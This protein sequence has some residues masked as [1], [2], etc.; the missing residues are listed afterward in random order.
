MMRW[1]CR[2]IYEANRSTEVSITSNRVDPYISNIRTDNEAQLYSG[3]PTRGHVP[4]LF[5]LINIPKPKSIK[6]EEKID[7]GMVSMVN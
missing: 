7:Y 2:V 3:A 1:P 6:K 4:V 5:D